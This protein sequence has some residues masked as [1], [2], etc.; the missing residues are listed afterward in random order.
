M[1]DVNDKTT[2]N[3]WHDLRWLAGY[4]P[5]N[6][7]SISAMTSML[8]LIYE[9]H[10]VLVDPAFDLFDPEVEFETIAAV[11]AV[12]SVCER[13]AYLVVT[14]HVDRMAEFF[15][16][17]ALV[18][19]PKL[20]PNGVGDS[21]IDSNVVLQHAPGPHDPTGCPTCQDEDGGCYIV[22]E[23][24][25]ADWPLPNVWLAVRVQNQSDAD[26]RIPTLCRTP[27]ARRLV[28]IDGPT[29]PIRLDSIQTAPSGAMY[30]RPGV[31]WAP[32]WN[33]LAKPEPCRPGVTVLVPAT[34]TIDG[35]IATGRTTPIHP[36]WIISLKCQCED[37]ERPFR[38]TGWGSWLPIG[39]ALTDDQ[40]HAHA[41]A[42]FG[43]YISKDGDRVKQEDDVDD[44]Y[45]NNDW[46]N[47][48]LTG[49]PNAGWLLDGKAHSESPEPVQ[50]R[51]C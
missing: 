24:F 6:G 25:P 11:F 43:E 44:L 40:Q 14:E 16:W 35:V 39:Q 15:K 42:R 48:C 3:E 20:F 30:G 17:C 21:L 32:L 2:R 45:D 23:G 28:W 10:K 46:S 41:G 29:G 33:A 26:A 12:M 34:P 37:Q 22:H 38:F 13:H 4:D 9:D 19:W 18:E 50:R 27:A 51:R 5:R 36:G 1:T 47:V 49:K 7:V 8:P 31:T